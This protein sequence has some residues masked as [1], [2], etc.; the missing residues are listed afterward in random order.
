M[1]LGRCA[2]LDPA[3]GTTAT[4]RAGRPHYHHAKVTNRLAMPPVKALVT[5]VLSNRWASQALQEMSVGDRGAEELAF[6]PSLGA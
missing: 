1:R 3:S 4:V 2:C 5:F 6:A